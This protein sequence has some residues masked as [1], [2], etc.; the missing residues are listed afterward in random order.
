M[1]RSV[2]FKILFNRGEEMSVLY[3][4]EQGACIKISGGKIVITKGNERLLQIPLL[5]V[6]HLSLFGNVQI[7]TQALQ[8][9][10]E[11]GCDISYFNYGGK[12]IG[13]TTSQESRNNFLRL[14]QYEVYNNATKRLEFAKTIVENKIDNQI[15]MITQHRW[16]QEK[17]DWKKDVNQMEKCKETIRNKD[18]V[19]SL[20]GVEGFCSN[21][22]FGAFSK[23]LKSEIKFKT[24]N[25]RPPRD[26]VN[27][28]LSLAYTFLTKEMC[29]LLEVES[30]ETYLGFLHGIKYGRKSLAL[31][32]IEEFRQ[33][34]I[35][36]MVL[37]LFNKRILTEEE[38]Q[39]KEQGVFLTEQGFQKFCIEYEKWMKDKYRSK[40]KEQVLLLRK[41]IQYGEV[42]IPYK[43]ESFLYTLN[44][45]ND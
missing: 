26:P 20:M 30:F 35:D 25:R 29:N 24:R 40:M 38:S 33:P 39:V 3:I 42:Y 34:V 44:R 14:A 28:M 8:K 13:H 37:M 7:T 23:M 19:S 6:T 22:Y 4:K 11:Q 21:I 17:Y 18:T 12:Y 36:C 1:D 2:N 41:A 43:Q 9:L 32:M 5:H 10:L 27:A 31:D 45:S 15:A 16:M